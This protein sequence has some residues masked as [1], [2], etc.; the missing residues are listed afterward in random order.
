VFK[1]LIEYFK[2]NRTERTGIL[3]VIVCIAAVLAWPCLKPVPNEGESGYESYA[4]E[5]A[6]FEKSLQQSADSAEEAR[7]LDFQ[8]MDRSLAE[9]KLKPFPFDP[10]TLPAADWSRMGMT[11]RQ[12][13]TIKNYLSKGGQF[14]KNEDLA[15][16]FCIT[17]SEYRILEPFIRIPAQAEKP[18]AEK[19]PEAKKAFEVLKVELNSADSVTLLKL[20]GIGPSFA[21]RI[22]K[23]RKLLG[24]F[25]SKEQL[26]EVYGFDRD[27][28][29]KLQA[30]CDADPS[31]ITRI[32]INRVK[33]EELKR[34]PYFPYAT[35][36][37]IVDQRIVLGGRFTSTDQI[38]KVPG[39]SEELFARIKPYL[40][41]E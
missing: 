14:R 3:L 40:L 29:D 23:Y 2:F 10:N 36:K 9:S 41:I 32:S 37:A 39:M 30:Y 26:L 24:G 13:R 27:R 11:D 17:E 25:Y 7:Q 21:K 22:L 38:R 1:K 31:L 6:R 4:A 5:I 34:H 15:R 35:A 18:F 19:K 33:T 8:Q 20:Y 16:M 12:I 28:Y